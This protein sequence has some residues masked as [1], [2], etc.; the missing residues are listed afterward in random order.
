MITWSSLP[1][2][3]KVLS[4]AT[5]M[6]IFKQLNDGRMPEDYELALLRKTGA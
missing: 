6:K 5:G 2:V 4:I 1:E 3:G